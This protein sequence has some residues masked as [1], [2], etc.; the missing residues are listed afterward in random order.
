MRWAQRRRRWLA[1]SIK[2]WGLMSQ[3]RERGQTLVLITVFMMSLLGMAAVAID[4]GSWYQQKRHVQ[5]VA[6]SA[7]LAG[8]GRLPAGWSYADAAAQAEFSSNKL[9]SDTVTIT[10]TTLNTANDSVTVTVH[11]T[12]PTFFAKLFSK[13]SVDI[14]GSARATVLSYTGVT[15]TGNVMPWGIMKGSYT[16]GASYPLEIDNAASPQSG[17]LDIPYMSACSGAN[18][19]NDYQSLIEGT[20]NACPL[21]IG[22]KLG[23]QSGAV[24]G[25]TSHGVDN[26][27]GTFKPVDQI[28][29][30]GTNGTA[31]ILDAA[32]PQ[33]VLLPIILN[34]D[35]T[36]NWPSGSG[37]VQIVGFAWFVITGYHSKGLKQYVDGVFV[38]LGG[39]NAGWTTGGWDHLPGGATTVSLTS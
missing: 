6:D 32:S 29:T 14:S 25:P 17:A 12:A 36:T 10:N 2:G 23:L 37:K 22:E 30:I 26:R 33:L 5:N 11:A 15:S 20:K 13:A 18:G 24:N 9:G 34:Q 27:I 38:S 7:A 35:G 1:V 19:S 16:P 8:A 39:S 21:S 31:T 4:V 3:R 28:I